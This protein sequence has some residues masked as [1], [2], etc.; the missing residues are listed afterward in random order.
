[1]A[2]VNTLF[3]IRDSS[4]KPEAQYKHISYKQLYFR[5][6]PRVAIDS[7][8]NEHQI[9]YQVSNDFCQF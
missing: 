9:W 7:A 3:S 8:E 4:E 1:M 2:E 5:V 6:A